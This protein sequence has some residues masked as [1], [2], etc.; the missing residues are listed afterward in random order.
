MSL[1]G[2]WIIN[3]SSLLENFND[4][5]KWYITFVNL[6][7]DV[8]SKLKST[9]TNIFKLDPRQSS[10]TIWWYGRASPFIDKRTPAKVDAP[11]QWTAFILQLDVKRWTRTTSADVSC[12]VHVAT[13]RTRQ[14]ATALLTRWSSSSISGNITWPKSNHFQALENRCNRKNL[15]AS[16]INDNDY[17]GKFSETWGNS[18]RIQRVPEPIPTW[19]KREIQEAPANQLWPA[20]RGWQ[21]SSPGSS[22]T[23]SPR[24]SV[25]SPTCGVNSAEGPG[26]PDG[27]PNSLYLS[28]FDGR[29]LRAVCAPPSVS[30]VPQPCALVSSRL[31]VPL[32]LAIEGLRECCSPARALLTIPHLSKGMQLKIHR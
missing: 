9:S 28:V 17:R 13:N 3:I 16:M 31:I 30:S 25:W 27:T 12:V 8:T 24:C 15:G 20:S 4:D 23:A 10:G 29:C 22:T 32:G 1:A 19:S 2:F 7:C 5:N 14:L 21:Q 6:D 26:L 11:Y 18:C